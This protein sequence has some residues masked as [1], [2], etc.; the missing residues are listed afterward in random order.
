MEIIVH[1]H[2]LFESI[3]NAGKT[4][5]NREF[6]KCKFKGCDFSNIDFSSSRFTDCTFTACN[7]GLMKLN[8]TSLNNVKFVECKLIGVN[9]SKCSD[10]LFS[11]EFENC[12]LDYASFA[13]KK[14]AKTPFKNCSLKNADFSECTLVKALFD[15]TDLLSAVFQKTNLQEANLATAYNF[16]IDPERN[17]IKKALFSQ[18]GLAGL[19]V[20]YGIQI[21]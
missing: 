14:M 17:F 7:L 10:L 2:K 5:K 19:L 13:G 8:E 6:E 21:V 4:I 18:Q 12:L 3:N 11:L 16:S 15:N 1:Q 20:K 9:F